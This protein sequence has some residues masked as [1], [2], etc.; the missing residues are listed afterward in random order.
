[1]SLDVYELTTKIYCSCSHCGQH[2]PINMERLTD[3]TGK[4][5]LLV[6]PCECLE[7]QPKPVDAEKFVQKILES[8]E[9]RKRWALFNLTPREQAVFWCA[10]LLRELE[11]KGDE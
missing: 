6:T 1:M 5:D 9:P 7:P 8:M 4:L 11:G 3:D 2:M 10:I